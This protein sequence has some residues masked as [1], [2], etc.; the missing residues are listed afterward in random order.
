MEATQ[1]GELLTFAQWQKLGLDV[2]GTLL[3]GKNGRPTGS[4]TFVFPN[5]H[6]KGRAHVAVFNWDG[7][8]K[9]EVDLAPVLTK[10][11]KFRVYNVLDIKQTIA[12]SQPVFTGI[13]DGKPVS[14]PMRKDKD[15]PDFDSFLV[16]GDAP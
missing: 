4:K 6:E 2:H 8:E 11:R 12:A 15:C 7:R 5:T 16:L 3:P 10:G 9:V 14:L 13:Y 1:P